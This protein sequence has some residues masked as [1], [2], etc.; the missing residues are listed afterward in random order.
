MSDVYQSRYE[1]KYETT[2]VVKPD[3]PAG[4]PAFSLSFTGTIYS[5]QNNDSSPCYIESKLEWNSLDSD[6]AAS[7]SF[8]GRTGPSWTPTLLNDALN[9]AV[10][11]DMMSSQSRL[12]LL[13]ELAGQ[14]ILKLS[15]LF[16]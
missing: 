3:E 10:R 2:L 15:A 11:M 6:S 13:T 16:E 5:R 8:S 12:E 9:G 4:M 7:L 1:R 14:F